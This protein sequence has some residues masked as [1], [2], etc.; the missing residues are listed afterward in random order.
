MF[1]SVVAP[2]LVLVLVVITAA[3]SSPAVA[4]AQPTGDVEPSM[5]R[6]FREGEAFFRNLQQIQS[7]ESFTQVIDGLMPSAEA[8]TITAPEIEL[9]L[10]SLSYRARAGFNVGRGDT[11][12][13]DLDSAIRLNPRFPCGPQL[14][15]PT[16]VDTCEELRSELVGLLMLTVDPPDAEVR[17][18]GQPFELGP[19]PV[20]VL[21]GSHGLTVNRAGYAGD[22][23][24]IDVGA[25]TSATTT[26]EVV[27]TRVSA[28]LRILTRPPGATV[29]VNTIQYGPTEGAADPGAFRP[30]LIEGYPVEESSDELVVPGMQPRM[31]SVVV[32]L[33]GYRTIRRELDLADPIDYDVRFLLERAEGTVVFDNV[34]Q[35]ATVNVV[36][37]GG[38]DAMELDLDAGQL[39]LP[40]GVYDLVVAHPEA[41]FHEDTATVVDRQEY[42][43]PVR[44]RPAL[45]VLGILGRDTV[46]RDALIRSLR[47]VFG[48]LDDWTF[49]DRT[50]AGGPVLTE[51][52]LT[53]EHLREMVNPRVVRNDQIDWNAVQATSSRE[54]QSSVYLVGVLDNDLSSS[55]ADLWMWRAP[56][57][58]P[59]PA[60]LRVSLTPG[61]PRGVAS[62]VREGFSDVR[63]ERA[64]LGA[65]LIDTGSEAG[66]FVV[67]VT[68]GGPAQQAGLVRGDV[69]LS[70][71]A[72]GVD[73]VDRVHQLLTDPS[74]STI[75]LGI[76]RAGVR[77]ELVLPVAT[78]PEIVTGREAAL[79]YP[80]L[81]ASLS[82]LRVRQETDQ[83]EWVWALNDA[84]TRLRAG[85]LEGALDILRRTEPPTPAGGGVGRGTLD[86]WLG[87]AY[88]AAGPQFR[89][90]ARRSFERAAQD[91]DAR[92]MHN[93]GPWVA[94]RARARL[95]WLDGAA[96]VSR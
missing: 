48:D 36:R 82:S 1:R 94:P 73:S 54:G 8:G 12:D 55:Y 40:I 32:T 78:S 53:T 88:T 9:L 79:A 69:L 85:D 63:I 71:D 25:G 64:W 81:A 5:L 67:Q 42:V 2:S 14:V 77:Q 28:V 90:Q 50:Q 30:D 38:G 76:D 65:L 7:I 10:S 89:A 86:Y 45:T 68:D 34:T 24:T 60:R 62:V 49:Q 13:G 11:V 37:Q 72:V 70:V 3:P 59:I 57:G 18:D 31:T 21:A 80:A 92:L 66:P 93:D 6:A 41:G 96:S 26:E 44:L 20:E 35:G 83:P 39:T 23:R 27:L 84:S 4:G 33:D 22:T 75:T 16:L 87:M 15:S 61:D 46:G 47:A 91:A 43:V 58:A 56:P 95:A 17:L 29:H 74:G 51:A 52:G 19:G